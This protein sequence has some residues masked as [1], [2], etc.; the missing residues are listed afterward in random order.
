M[1][2][3]SV[4]ILPIIHRQL[5]LYMLKVL[6]PIGDLLSHF[7]MVRNNFY[8]ILFDGGTQGAFGLQL[9]IGM[10]ISSNVVGP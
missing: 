7:Q 6:L 9:E 1:K 4:F 5:K 10:I 2:I 3:R 8:E